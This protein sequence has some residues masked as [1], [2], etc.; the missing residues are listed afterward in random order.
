[1]MK[2][3]LP[4]LCCLAMP[5][6]AQQSSPNGRYYENL[7][8]GTVVSI[9]KVSGQE[10]GYVY[11]PPGEDAVELVLLF[12]ANPAYLDSSGVVYAPWILD[13]LLAQGVIPGV[14]AFFPRHS[15]SVSREVMEQIRE[16]YPRITSEAIGHRLAPQEN[17]AGLAEELENLIGSEPSD[18]ITSGVYTFAPPEKGPAGFAGSTDHFG[19]LAMEQWALPP[20][21]GA[22][23]IRNAAKEQILILREGTLA[24]TLHDTTYRLE[25][26]S[27][28]FLAAGDSAT[29]V[30]EKDTVLAYRMAYGTP[31][32]ESRRSSG[33]SF[34]VD[35]AAVPFHPHDRGGLRD[36]FRRSTPYC[37]YYEMHMT[38]LNPGIKSHEPH[39]HAAAEIV[40]M[41]EGSTEMEIGDH[42]FTG[43]R[44]DVY[45]LPSQEPHAI[46]NLGD[47]PCRYIAFQWH[48]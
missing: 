10:P 23:P 14:A 32:A 38:T 36:Y 31:N 25:P 40:I 37:P 3:W 30:A 5:V 18:R 41:V 24:L 2:Y 19:A 42:R 8:H 4:I 15:N 34:I 16:E 27:V 7:D 21:D 43:R 33:N 17:V 45:Y 20:A 48:N 26:N 1:M 28:V 47:Q 9:E 13:N 44:G 11:L 46:R 29:V 6:L 12:D 35:Y 39:V 22:I